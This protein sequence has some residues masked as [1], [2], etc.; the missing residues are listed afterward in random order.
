M[1]HCRSY[2][3]LTAMLPKQGL[4]HHVSSICNTQELHIGM[5]I[6]Q[7]GHSDSC[8]QFHLVIP[9]CPNF[10]IIMVD[11]T[12]LHLNLQVGVEFAIYTL[13]IYKYIYTFKNCESRELSQ[14]YPDAISTPLIEDTKRKICLPCSKDRCPHPFSPSHEIVHD[15]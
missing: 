2:R 6:L 14:R 11:E 3:N 10:N 1:F 12:A 15:K 4:F 13:Y 9:F 7:L 5:Q 8:G